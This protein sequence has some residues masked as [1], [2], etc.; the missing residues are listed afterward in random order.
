MRLCY[1]YLVNIIYRL[2]TL[3]VIEILCYFKENPYMN[4]LHLTLSKEPFIEILEGRKKE[5]YREDKDFWSN[6]FEGKEGYYT[7]ILFRNGY[8]AT[9]PEMLVECKKI[10]LEYWVYENG[11]EDFFWVLKLGKILETKYIKPYSKA[12]KH[13]LTMRPVTRDPYFD[14]IGEVS[15]KSTK[16]KAGKVRKS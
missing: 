16:G 9:A 10:Q 13:P 11:E 2:I 8:S 7:H 3:A 6:R 1:Q 14:L 15:M 5:E 4:L 12:Q